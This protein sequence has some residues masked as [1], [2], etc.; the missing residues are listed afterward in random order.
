MSVVDSSTTAPLVVRGNSLY[1]IVDG[2]SWTQAEANSVKLGGHLVTINDAAERR[3]LSTNLYGNKLHIDRLRNNSQVIF[4]LDGYFV[5]LN[6]KTA[7]GI[8]Q[9]AGGNATNWVDPSD[10]IHPAYFADKGYLL[11]GFEYGAVHSNSDGLGPD[12]VFNLGDTHSYYANDGIF[13]RGIAETPSSAVVILV[14]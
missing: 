11:N 10:Y 8:F 7:N 12:I 14:M 9:W 13:Y 4:D 2:P 1:T 6:D 3:W 5:G